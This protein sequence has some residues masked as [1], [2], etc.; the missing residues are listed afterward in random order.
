MADVCP[1]DLSGGL[2]GPSVEF[3][4]VVEGVLVGAHVGGH[5]AGFGS[6]A[7]GGVDQHG[8]ADPAEGVE[9][10]FDGQIVAGAVGLQ[11]QEVGQLQGQHAGEGVHGDVVVGPVVHRGER[12][13]VGVFELSE[14]E[15][16]F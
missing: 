10:G 13:L 6:A 7:G 11:S 9:E 4:Q 2:W 12:H 16:D 8:L 1:Y 14:P 15:F 3:E 5:A